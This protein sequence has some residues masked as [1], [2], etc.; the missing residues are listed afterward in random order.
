MDGPLEYPGEEITRLRVCLNDL[1]R[2]TAVRVLSAGG[3]PSQICSALL[4][5]LIGILPL[6]FAFVRLNDPEGA[7]HRDD[8]SR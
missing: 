5:L 4:D 3:E 6:S 8:A 1:A 2:I 7:L